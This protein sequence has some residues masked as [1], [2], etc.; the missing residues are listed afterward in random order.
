MTFNTIKLRTALY[1]RG[2]TQKEVA[3]IAGTS[4]SMVSA[5]FNGRG[6]SQQTAQKI[7]D[8]LG[9]NLDTIKAKG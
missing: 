3:A 7:A 8:A 2:I 5:I 4:Y 1:K 6:C 9:V